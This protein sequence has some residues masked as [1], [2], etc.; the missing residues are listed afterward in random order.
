MSDE[1]LN[2]LHEGIMQV[3]DAMSD[4]LRSLGQRAQLVADCRPILDGMH[5]QLDRLQDSINSLGEQIH[6]RR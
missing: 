4:L 6:F 1:Y 5:Y 3:H 2:N